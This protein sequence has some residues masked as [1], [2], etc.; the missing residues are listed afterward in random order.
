[1]PVI[2]LPAVGDARPPAIV[3]CDLCIIG[4][5]PAGSTLAREL[6]GTGLRVTL[7]ESGGV[8]RDARIDALNTVENVGYPRVDDQW[9]VRNRIVG[10]SSYTWGG[11]C[12]P[13]DA[14]DL[15]R[16]PWI[17]GSGW[18]LT[19]DEFAPY[20]DRSAAYLGLA[21]GNGFSD[22]R[23]WTLAGYKKPRFVP[24]TTALL[25][26]FWQ[27]SRDDDES[28]LYEYMRVGRRL[29]ERLGPNVT[30]VTGA[31]VLRVNPIASGR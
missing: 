13:F 27:F 7:L 15:E 9:A 25:P 6:S 23:F 11:R 19:I 4:S 12:A 29:N 20:L 10:G 28:Y 14:I 21:V 16:R 1:M 30:M 2:D 24:Q 8:E 31:T 3:A 22:E 18:P 26:F 5:G 17:A